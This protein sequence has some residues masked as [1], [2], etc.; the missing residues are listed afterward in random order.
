MSSRRLSCIFLLVAA[1]G[2]ASA[3]GEEL[4]EVDCNAITVPTYS[5]LTVLETCSMCHSSQRTGANRFGAPVGVDFDNYN[6][7]RD[8]SE[9]AMEEMYEGKMPPPG[10]EATEQEKQDFYAWAQCGFPP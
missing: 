2:M 3:C 5:Q 4:P 8:N 10:Y 9:H 6:G 1:L 7:A